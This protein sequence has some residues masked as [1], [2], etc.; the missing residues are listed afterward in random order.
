MT[1]Y[2]ISL[3]EAEV[4]ALET[5]MINIQDWASNAVK[6]R[7]KMA[8]KAIV[9]ALISHCNANDIAIATGYDAQIDQAY[10]LG[11]AEKATA[12]APDQ[13]E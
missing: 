4:K 7:S 6:A 1:N 5:V 3:T 2:T 11:I 8:G 10:S 12:E 9:N 13:P